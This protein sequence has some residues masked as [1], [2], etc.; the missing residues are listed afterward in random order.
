M[1]PCKSNENKMKNYVEI[2]RLFPA[3][4]FWKANS[5]W[6]PEPSRNKQE[7]KEKEGEKHAT[8]SWIT[9]GRILFFDI[10]TTLLTLH[11]VES[12]WVASL[13]SNR[14]TTLQIVLG[15][16]FICVLII[17]FQSIERGSVKCVHWIPLNYLSAKSFNDAG[18]E[19]E[20]KYGAHVILYWGNSNVWKHNS[21]W[22][23]Y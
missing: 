10:L 14:K 23:F 2:S 22:R 13:D 15:Y 8:D 7:L 21:A 4:P 6:R 20:S 1:S 11:K 16:V 17:T 5:E 12:Q 9:D 19:L 18:S 3:S